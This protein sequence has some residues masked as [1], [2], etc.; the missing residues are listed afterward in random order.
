MLIIPDM[1][2]VT[3]RPLADIFQYEREHRYREARSIFEFAP[4]LP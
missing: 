3:S 2:L 4:A 1:V